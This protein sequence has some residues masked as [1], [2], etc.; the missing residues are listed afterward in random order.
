MLDAAREAQDLARGKTRSDFDADRPL[1]LALAHLLQTIGEAARRVSE[2]FRL[3]HPEI[4]WAPIVGLRHRIVHDYMHVDF[5]IVWDVVTR[6]LAP[7][8]EQLE[9]VAPAE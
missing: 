6:D 3:A 1:S 2:P 4:P 9:R 5:D 7:L 8:V